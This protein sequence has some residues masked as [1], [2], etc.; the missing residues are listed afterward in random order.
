VCVFR[1]T[2]PD[3]S[4][5]KLFLVRAETTTT[6]ATNMIVS[7]LLLLLHTHTCK[8]TAAATAAATALAWIASPTNPQTRRPSFTETTPTLTRRRGAAQQLFGTT[9][10]VAEDTIFS[11][12]SSPRSQC[13]DDSVAAA[14]SIAKAP[15]PSRRAWM[16]T[17]VSAAAGAATAGGLAAFGPSPASSSRAA[18]AATLPD[19]VINEAVCDPTV[20]VW[21]N[22]RDDR[23]VYLL[24]TAH[25]S[26]VS[27]E[28]AGTLV[29]TVHPNAV[30]VELDLKRVGGIALPTQAQRN[31]L[32]PS[33]EAAS[34]TAAG[35]AVEDTLMATGGPY[36][37]PPTQ[38]IVPR[39]TQSAAPILPGLE[40]SSTVAT[41]DESASSSSSPLQQQQ[42]PSGGIGGWFRG[43]VLNFASAAVGNAIRGMYNSLN[44]AG[45][46][47]G[48]E[49]ATAIV[50]GQKIDASIVLGDQDVEITMNRLTQALAA[51]DLN[52]L[53][54]A[55]TELQKSMNELL[56]G[57][58]GGAQPELEN[59]DDPAV[60]RRELSEYV[61]K[62]KSR[63]NVRKI[64]GQLQEAAP[65]LV[66][67]MLTERDAY[68]ARGLDTLNQFE[69]IVAVMGIAHLD[70][71]EQNL[72]S[73]G[74][75]QVPL[76]C[77]TNRQQQKRELAHVR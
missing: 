64:M 12:S 37:T 1:P 48:E 10:I 16:Q 62:L 32:P 75:K 8:A 28:L 45:F 55:D 50:E 42:Q 27:A 24:G 43:R 44:Q 35:E 58:P 65:A 76:R 57:G 4:I 41:I 59:Y 31:L 26:Q 30:F 9:P 73:K 14:R 71:V 17:I 6:I 60:Y 21:R 51:T 47:P 53:F 18:A 54:S 49:F 34:A 46:N 23:L 77:P 66:Q 7:L 22:G 3:K 40:V 19:I 36:G 13:D 38:V 20:S 56:P 69:C 67:V 70:G 15:F 74:W 5:M 52:R 11:Y 72:R 68:M 2:F 33:N 29:R 25:I 63:D 61:E 39:V